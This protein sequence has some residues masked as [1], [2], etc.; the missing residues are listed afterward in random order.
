MPIVV[1]LPRELRGSIE[2]VRAVRLEGRQPVAVGE[3]TRSVLGEEERS[4][5]H[6]NLLPVTY[7]T[8]DVAGA[9]D[10]CQS[11]LAAAHNMSL[12]ASSR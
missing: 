8:A 4:L 9:A 6:K 5:Y 7:V 2:A 3:V 10:D 1:R 11:G 12:T